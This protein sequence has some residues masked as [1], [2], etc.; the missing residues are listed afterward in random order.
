MTNEQAMKMVGEAARRV[1][2]FDRADRRNGVATPLESG[3]EQWAACVI[4]A[5]TAAMVTEDWKTVAD[6]VVMLEQFRQSV[7]RPG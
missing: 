1:A 3:P 5:L 7:P 4:E 6:A 2:Q